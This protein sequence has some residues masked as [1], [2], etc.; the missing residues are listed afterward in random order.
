[1]LLLSSLSTRS[2]PLLPRERKHRYHQSQMI[3]G[4]VLLLS[5]DT[6]MQEQCIA[7]GLDLRVNNIVQYSIVQYSIVQCSIVQY[8]VVGW[9]ILTTFLFFYFSLSSF[10]LPFFSFFLLY[11]PLLSFIILG[12]LMLLVSLSLKVFNLFIQSLY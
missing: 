12:S 11:Y 4:V 2:T 7:E 6:Q 5:T 9:D 10:S 8:R 1:M 3:W